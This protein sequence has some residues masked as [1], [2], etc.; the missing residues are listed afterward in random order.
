M[1][2]IK[3]S[4]EQNPGR[5]RAKEFTSANLLEALLLQTLTDTLGGPA[6]GVR[7]ILDQAKKM[8]SRHLAMSD[9]KEWALVITREPDGFGLG[10]V[11]LKNLAKCVSDRSEF[12]AHMVLTLIYL[13]ARLESKPKPKLKSK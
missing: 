3:P 5:G 9:F 2:I 11:R 4:G 1:G 10:M 7:D 6:S 8:V 13:S 12:G